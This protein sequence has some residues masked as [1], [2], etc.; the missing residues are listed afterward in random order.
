MKT[1]NLQKEWKKITK[2][3]HNKPKC[4]TPYPKKVVSVRDLLLFA[5]VL[6]EKIGNRENILFNTE[7]YQKIM[8]GYYRQKSSLRI[9]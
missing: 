1:I 7:L 8:A 2:E 3:V 4:K 6:L 9:N 5:Q